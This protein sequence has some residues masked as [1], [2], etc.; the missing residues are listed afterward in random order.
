M[1]LFEFVC[2]GLLTVC[3]GLCGDGVVRVGCVGVLFR[4]CVVVG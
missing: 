2:C 3:F 1:L 4:F